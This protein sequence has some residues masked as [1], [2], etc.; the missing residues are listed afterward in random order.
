[1]EKEKGELHSIQG[2]IEFDC[3]LISTQVEVMF[4]PDKTN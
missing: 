3:F 4:N 1:M 2:L